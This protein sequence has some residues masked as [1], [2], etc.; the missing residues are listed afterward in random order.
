MKDVLIKGVIFDKDGTL[1]DYGEVWGPVVKDCVDTILMTFDLRNKDKIRREIYQIIGVD[2]EGRVYQ[3]GFLFNHDKL[4]R[5]VLRIFRFCVVNR[6]SPAAMY[7]II[8]RMLNSQNL[9][10]VRKIHSMDFSRLQDLFEELDSRGMVIGVV[11]NDIT[12]NTKAILDGMG[13]SRHVRFLRTKESNCRRKP[14]NESIKQFCTL[15][16]LKSEEV[17]VV[18][19]SVVDM[20]YAKAGK[21]GYTVAVLTGYGNGEVLSQWADVVYD[22][23]EDLVDD[24]VL[25]PPLL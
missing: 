13:I 17:A 3:D 11:T 6:I 7:R 22:K 19:D 2:D 21:V 4:V 18:G 16:G 5:I 24:S 9:K 25:L 12:A 14:S 1:F 20:E 15:F 10:V 8:T 23:V